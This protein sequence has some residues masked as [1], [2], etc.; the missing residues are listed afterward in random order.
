MNLNK[1]VLILFVI[2]LSIINVVVGQ[3]RI[4]SPYSRYGIGSLQNRNSIFSYSMGNLSKSISSPTVINFGNPA[5]YSAFDS[6]SFVFDGA[7]ISSN[8]NLL[9]GVIQIK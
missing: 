6:M 4:S 3:N 8:T 2:L 1:K 5:S 9:Y 7:L